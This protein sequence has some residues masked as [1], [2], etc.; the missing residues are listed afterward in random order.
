MNKNAW[1]GGDRV[2]ERMNGSLGTVV[3]IVIVVGAL[4]A[5]TLWIDS[6]VD[7]VN[8]KVTA[9][10]RRMILIQSD[11]DKRITA[12]EGQIGDRWRGEHQRMW[13]GRLRD[14]NPSLLV[15]A[16]DDVLRDCTKRGG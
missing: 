1:L 16:V 7:A 6:S 13:A 14:R 5:A 4:L 15:P 8:E 10:D 12:V 11:V 9:L 2:V 3:N